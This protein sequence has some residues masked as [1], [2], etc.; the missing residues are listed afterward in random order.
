LPKDKRGK[1][2]G[3]VESATYQTG[4]INLQP[5]DRLLLYTDGIYEVFAGNQEF[6]MDGFMRAKADRLG[7]RGASGVRRL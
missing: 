1:V 3:L 2:L 6:G 7:I 5:A 4:Q